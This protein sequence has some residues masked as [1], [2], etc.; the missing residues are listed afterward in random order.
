MWAMGAGAAPSHLPA[1][2][3]W[4]LDERG[5][6]LKATWRLS[7]GFIN[8]SIWRDDRCFDTFHLAPADAARLIAFLVNGLADVASVPAAAPVMNLAADPAPQE[9][10]NLR[11]RLGRYDGRL[12]TVIAATLRK[13]ADRL[14]P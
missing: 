10:P 1:G 9:G 12:R 4:L 7:H 2:S 14:A 11:E 6:A 8:L 13:T 3:T 5:V